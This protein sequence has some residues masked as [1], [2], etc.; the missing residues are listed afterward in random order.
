MI[1]RMWAVASTPFY[2]IWT[3]LGV[4]K[5]I[6]IRIHEFCEQKCGKVFL[7]EMH[8]SQKLET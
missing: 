6:G 7:S 1:L 8:R 4:L 2:N 3:T 5:Q